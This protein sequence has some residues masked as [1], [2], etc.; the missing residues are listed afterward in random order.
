LSA[1]DQ[2][3]VEAQR[4]ALEEQLG[5]YHASPY[6]KRFDPLDSQAAAGQ[7][8]TF[9]DAARQIQAAVKPV[10]ET[11]D[12]ASGGQFNKWNNAA[13]QAQKIMRSATTLDAAD[14]AEARLAE[15][16]RN[17]DE[18]L[19]RHAG[20]VS[21]TDYMAAREAWKASSR[22][23]ELHSVFE[24]MMNGVTTEETDRG[25]TQVMTGRTKS[26]QNYLAKGENLDQIEKLIGREGVTNLKQITLL[27]SKANTARQTIGVAKEVGQEVA[28]HLGRAGVGSL[29]GSIAG[30][31][32]GVAAYPATLAG[33][34]AGEGARYVLR[35]AATNPRVGNMVEYAVR[36]GISPKVYAPLIA[37]AIAEPFQQPQQPEA[38]AEGTQ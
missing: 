4:Q 33:A 8:R 11:L 22:L 24:R 30:K 23:G 17:I 21:R 38:A 36:N 18:L 3:R 16:N 26:L 2:A 25:L 1:A 7:V 14:A 9:G 15:A 19:T 37:R 20:D 29:I 35:Y 10:Y 6:A 31:M 34:M 27:L 28:R 5:V 12:R 13:K 32:L